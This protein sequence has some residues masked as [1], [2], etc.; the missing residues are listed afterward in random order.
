[1]ENFINGVIT[2]VA[3]FLGGWML[4]IILAKKDKNENSTVTNP[5]NEY[6]NIDEKTNDTVSISRLLIG[7][8]LSMLSAFFWGIGNVASRYTAEQYQNSSF[9]IAILHYFSASLVLFIAGCL[10]SKGTN[11]QLSLCIKRCVSNHYFFLSAFSKA[12]NTY[13]WLYA[14]TLVQATY[15]ATLEN[16]QIVWTVLILVFVFRVK[17]PGD[18]IVSALVVI[19]GG[20][21]IIDSGQSL[22]FSDSEKFGLLLSALSGLGFA[23]F[24]ILWSMKGKHVDTNLATRSIEVSLLMLISL[25]F[26]CI[27]HSILWF[28]GAVELFSV[29][30]IPIN[31]IFIQTLVG[32]FTIA[33]TYFLINEALHIMKSYPHYSVIIVGLGVSYAVFFTV[34]IEAV[35]NKTS[36]DTYQ[37]I[38]VVL[39]TIGFVS[40][41][42][43]VVSIHA[44]LSSEKD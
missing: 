26:V 8:I 11:F 30:E 27:I 39:F 37:W 21:L 10:M 32:I 9:D 16:M 5:T 18:W 36:I 28:I 15:V 22:E 38:G 42:K 17:V 44:P 25:V 13:L 34:V 23:F 31:H 20:F 6:V 4:H 33:C 12:A 24:Y 35:W 41:R 40:V 43:N 7:L 2:V 19:T 29:F 3:T 14:I 1:M